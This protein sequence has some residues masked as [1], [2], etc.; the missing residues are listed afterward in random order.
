MKNTFYWYVFEDG[1]RVCV[2]GFSRTELEHEEQ[3][4]G[5]VVRMEEA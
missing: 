5:K 4:H 3:K 1:Y 2:R